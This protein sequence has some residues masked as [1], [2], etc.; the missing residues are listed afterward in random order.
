VAD[1]DEPEAYPFMG[2]SYAL[3]RGNMVN[4]TDELCNRTTVLYRFL[5]W[6]QMTAYAEDSAEH[7]GFGSLPPRV[8]NFT[9][10]MLESATCNGEF[11][12]QCKRQIF[13]SKSFPKKERCATILELITDTL[14]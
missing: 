2:M 12:L 4:V 3:F 9:R 14:P 6:T 7:W 10:A 13:G 8:R 5:R 1:L 11:I